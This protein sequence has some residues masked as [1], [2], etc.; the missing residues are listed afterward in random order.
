MGLTALCPGT[1]DP[2]TNGHIDIIER[3]A[4]RFDA[5]IVGVLDNPAK[6]PLFGAEER[7]GMLKQAVDPLANV[8]VEAFSG[9][10]VE[11][12]T[13]RGS[14]RR[15]EGPPGGDRFRV[16]DPDGADEPPARRRRDLVHDHESAVVV[17]VLL[18]GQGGR[19]LRRGR[20]HPRAGPTSPSGSQT[21]SGERRRWIS[22]PA[23]PSSRRWCATRSRCPCRRRR[24]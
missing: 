13:R 19:A 7:V 5:L 15:G 20:V 10:L 24:C 17:P 16:R 4:R 1:F 23:C 2:V 12:A 6:E 21:S 22:P 14:R 3:A 8:E 11:Y 18:P 9:L